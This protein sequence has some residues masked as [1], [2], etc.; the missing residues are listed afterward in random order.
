[1]STPRVIRAEEVMKISNLKSHYLRSPSVA[2]LTGR[3][4][5]NPS[6][7]GHFTENFSFLRWLTCTTS[8]LTRQMVKKK[9]WTTSL[10]SLIATGNR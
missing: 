6:S 4:H 3:E 10:V 8:T 1:M 7:S 5:S 2:P 9:C